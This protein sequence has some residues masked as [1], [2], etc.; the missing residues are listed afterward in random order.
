MEAG[1][2]HNAGVIH[3]FVDGINQYKWNMM[4]GTTP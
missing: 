1:G 4:P 3:D 2:V